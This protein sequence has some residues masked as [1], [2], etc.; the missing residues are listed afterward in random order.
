MPDRTRATTAH[1]PPR[2]GYDPF[3]AP[4][5]HKIRTHWFT[6]RHVRCK[7]T[8]TSDYLSN[9]WTMLELTVIAAR[10]TPVPITETGFLAH[11]IDTDELK[12]AG[13]TV[14]FFAS[15]MDREAKSKRY[16]EADYLWRQGDLL[17]ALVLD[18]MGKE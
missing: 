9:G 15:W 1:C 14:A 3:A 16:Q 10:D 2:R 17:D 6:W 11:G 13:G 12:A 7:V 4:K 5:R 8:E 18:T